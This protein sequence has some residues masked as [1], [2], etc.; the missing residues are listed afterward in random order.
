[1]SLG[2]GAQ[3]LALAL[4]IEHLSLDNKCGRG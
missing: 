2:A 4:G 1:M 3:N